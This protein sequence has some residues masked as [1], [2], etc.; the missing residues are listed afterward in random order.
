M[1]KLFMKKESISIQ[2][3]DI[4]EIFNKLKES[5]KDSKIN[6]KDGIRFDF[7]SSWVHVRASNT[8]PIIRIIAEAK[9]ENDL[10]TLL[11]NTK[12]KIES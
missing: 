3:R 4:K 10:Q 6:D 9:S 11:K 7:T 8:E 2:G 5:Y 12:E 1:P